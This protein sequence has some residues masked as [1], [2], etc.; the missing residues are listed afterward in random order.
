MMWVT[1]YKNIYFHI[2]NVQNYRNYMEYGAELQVTLTA[3]SLQF[4]LLS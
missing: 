3:E 4:I 2:R 1:L